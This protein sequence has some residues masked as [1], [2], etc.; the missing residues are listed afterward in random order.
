M[1]NKKWSVLVVDDE[2][3]NIKIISSILQDEYKVLAATS[4]EQA[5]KLTTEQQPDIVLLDM[6][7]PEMNGVEV[8]QTLKKD[9][10]T[11]DIPVIFVTVMDDMANEE[12]GFKAGAADYIAKPVHPLVLKARIKV[13]IDYSHYVQFL[14]NL[15]A[16]R[17][18]DAKVIKAE[19]TALL[20]S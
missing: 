16:N 11:R 3:A 8:C 6:M 7:M 4:G 15:L 18:L 9:K 5:I 19:V 14:E 1:T 13:H 12:V 10:A 20:K 17:K 2:P